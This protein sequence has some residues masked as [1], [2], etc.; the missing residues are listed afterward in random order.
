MTSANPGVR[1]SL[2]SMSPTVSFLPLPSGS[3]STTALRAE[4]SS[5]VVFGFGRPN[6]SNQSWR[7]HKKEAL[8]IDELVD[9]IAINFPPKVAD[10]RAVLPSSVMI[11]FVN[12]VP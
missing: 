12:G 9:G 11:S 7:P 6:F 8:S 4:Y 1:K 2:L 3:C 5:S 10:S